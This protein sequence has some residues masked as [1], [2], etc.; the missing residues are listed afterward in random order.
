[1]E[2]VHAVIE[3]TMLPHTFMC[4]GPDGYTKLSWS[5]RSPLVWLV[6]GCGWPG[7]CPVCTALIVLGC[8]LSY[9]IDSGPSCHSVKC[10]YLLHTDRV[11]D[12]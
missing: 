5:E 2:L 1:M 8:L 6:P 10:A 11:W 7:L 9:V 12:C 4:L 3:L